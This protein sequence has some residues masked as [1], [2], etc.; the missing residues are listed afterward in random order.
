LD[1]LAK[2]WRRC[3]IRWPSRTKF[4]FAVDG[5][6]GLDS[7]P[8]R[9]RHMVEESLKRLKTDRIDLYPAPP[10]WITRART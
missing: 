2:R 1:P 6:N 3:A 5:T 10:S 7:R 8:E 9:I 4:G